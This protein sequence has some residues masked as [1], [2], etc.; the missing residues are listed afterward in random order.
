VTSKY[1]CQPFTQ[2]DGARNRRTAGRVSG[3]DLTVELH[4]ATGG[5]HVDRVREHFFAWR[6][7]LYQNILFKLKRLTKTTHHI[8]SS[9]PAAQAVASS[10]S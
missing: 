7:N 4:L 10:P 2:F 1:I 9:P 5:A 6:N 3:I 8:D